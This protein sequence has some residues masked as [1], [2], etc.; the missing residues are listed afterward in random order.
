MHVKVCGITMVDDAVNAA[1]LG[2]SAIGLN[3]YPKSKRFVSAEQARQIL[4]AMP[5][6]VEVVGLFVEQS[7]SEIEAFLSA[8]GLEGIRTIQVHG[9]LLDSNLPTRRRVIA[10]FSLRDEMSI[11][12]ISEYESQCCEHGVAPAAILV[13]AHVPGEYGGTGKVASWSLAKRVQTECPLILAGGLTPAN[14]HEAIA[15]VRPYAVDVASGVESAP[16]VKDANLIMQF[17]RE[18]NRD[19]S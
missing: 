1:N 19:I 16:G 15:A 9:H 8:N 12:N 11:Q 7:C 14:V 2:V 5:L 17:L 3:F 6:F 13:D 4:K 10:A 18:S